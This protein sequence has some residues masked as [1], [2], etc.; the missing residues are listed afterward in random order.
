MQQQECHQLERHLQRYSSVNAP[1]CSDTL[2]LGVSGVRSLK[3]WDKRAVRDGFATPLTL[4]IFS[5]HRNRNGVLFIYLIKTGSLL[6]LGC[7]A[8][9]ASTERRRFVTR[10][11]EP[12]SYFVAALVTYSLQVRQELGIGERRRIHGPRRHTNARKRT[13][14]KRS[15]TPS[16]GSL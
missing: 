8:F 7:S 2:L 11:G 12:L 6:C 16:P 10:S 3:I 5:I 4:S 13:R 15:F 9:P 14:D 1:L